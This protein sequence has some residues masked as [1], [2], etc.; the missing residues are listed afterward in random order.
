MFWVYYTYSFF[1]V[2]PVGTSVLVPGPD[3]RRTGTPQFTRQDTLTGP[4]SCR[5]ALPST[6]RS[7]PATGFEVRRPP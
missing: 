4:G 5:E 6:V 2:F 3:T 1:S 7:S